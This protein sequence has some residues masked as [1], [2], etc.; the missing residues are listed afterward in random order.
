MHPSGVSYAGLRLS[1]LGALFG[2]LWLVAVGLIAQDAP[3]QTETIYDLRNAGENGI[4][5]PKAVSI[6]SP[7]T[8]TEPARGRSEARFFFP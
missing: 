5:S 6:P 3:Q 1:V 8:P 4:T 7:N 2:C